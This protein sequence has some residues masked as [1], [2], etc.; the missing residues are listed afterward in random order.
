MAGE[1]LKPLQIGTDWGEG[2]I[3]QSVMINAGQGVGI[4]AGAEVDSELASD[5]FARIREVISHMEMGAAGM[6]MDTGVEEDFY[7]RAF[8]EVFNWEHSHIG[9]VSPQDVP[10]RI[11]AYAARFADETY[12]P[13]TREFKEMR[14]IA[15][16]LGGY[17]GQWDEQAVRLNIGGRELDPRLVNAF[18]EG[19]N[20]DRWR[21]NDF[22]TGTYHDIV[23]KYRENQRINFGTETKP[24]QSLLTGTSGGGVYTIPEFLDI[25]NEQKQ[26]ED[27]ER[28]A[29][30]E[31]PGP[32]PSQADREREYYEYVLR[33]A[34]LGRLILEI[35]SWDD[36]GLRSAGNGGNAGNGNNNQ[37][38]NERQNQT[39][40]QT[41]DI[42]P[43][44]L[45]RRGIIDYLS[46]LRDRWAA[47]W[48]RRMRN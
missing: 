37:P 29:R 13:S 14:V 1:Q 45:A 35:D 28:L 23:H 19:A 12:A 11:S 46:G 41:Y 6:N 17:E 36:F 24:G 4:P 33:R 30:G 10:D 32:K 3:L 15:D 22:Q 40:T 34:E 25:K 42:D 8:D 27:R 43:D 21:M 9:E 44:L 48:E 7:R 47:G 18:L 26:A 5:P 2:S 16:M 39:Q 38:Q 31:R 20:P